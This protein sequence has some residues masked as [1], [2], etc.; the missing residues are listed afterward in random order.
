MRR[1]VAVILS[2]A[3][4]L[5]VSPYAAAQAGPPPTRSIP[6]GYVLVPS[7]APELPA[8]GTDDADGQLDDKWVPRAKRTTFKLGRKEAPLTHRVVVRR[9]WGLLI[10]GPVLTAAGVG[11]SIA[12]ATTTSTTHMAEIGYL[13][14]IIVTLGPGIPLTIVGSIPKRYAV[15]ISDGSAVDWRGR[16]TD[17]PWMLG[18]AASW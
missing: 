5:A 16:A 6:P 15:P 7:P 9:R 17:S 11:L 14:G 2:A 12:A 10:P 3:C 18:A 1:Y 4:V 13:F 8:A